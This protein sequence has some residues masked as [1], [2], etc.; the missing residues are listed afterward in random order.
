MERAGL[1]STS[2]HP[3]DRRA[4]HASLTRKARSAFSKGIEALADLEHEVL[5]GLDKSEQAQLVSLL[6]RILANAEA[7]SGAAEVNCE[8][9]R[10]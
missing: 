5:R 10:R 1:V 7:L 4:T 3:E 6:Q 9:R 8:G 2:A